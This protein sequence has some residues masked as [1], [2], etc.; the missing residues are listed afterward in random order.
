[1]KAGDA[2]IAPHHHTH[3]VVALEHHS[4]LL[5]QFSPRRDDYLPPDA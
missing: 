3:G 2:F 4:L 5:D 1:L